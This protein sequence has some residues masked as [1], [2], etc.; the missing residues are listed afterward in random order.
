M[1]LAQNANHV[2][3]I[4][5][6]KLSYHSKSPSAESFKEHWWGRSYL[7]CS[8]NNWKW[9]HQFPLI[10][11]WWPIFIS[12]FFPAH[13]LL[14]VLRDADGGVVSVNNQKYPAVHIK[15][16]ESE[17]L[18]ELYFQKVDAHLTYSSHSN[19]QGNLIEVIL[20]T[21]QDKIQLL[22]F[23]STKKCINE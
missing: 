20:H 12:F 7:C 16:V 9:P 21:L 10:F 11:W 17:A 2:D 19:E 8:V 23:I 13:F 5:R 15:T 3:I 22:C 14:I 4:Q 18:P 1:S 6:P